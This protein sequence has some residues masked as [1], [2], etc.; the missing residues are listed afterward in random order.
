M[1]TPQF[2]NLRGI[3]T[4]KMTTDEMMALTRD[5]NAN[6]SNVNRGS[7]SNCLE[8]FRP[9]G[10]YRSILLSDGHQIKEIF[11]EPGQRLSLQSHKLRSEHWIVTKGP[12]LVTIDEKIHELVSG[13]H[14]FIPQGA[15]H[16][17]ANPGTEKIKIV[18]IQIGDYLGE[19]DIIR[20]ED[21]YQRDIK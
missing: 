6:D 2:H 13:S 18:E 15:R 21:D 14:I 7:S 19:D 4:T 16:R 20:Y 1:A 5:H 11:V 3:T 8:V 17:L 9:W 10:S 12:V